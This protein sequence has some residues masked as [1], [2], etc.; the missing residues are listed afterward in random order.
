M[1]FA[2]QKMKKDLYNF[3]REYWRL[4]SEVEI[5][6]LLV[7]NQ[8]FKATTERIPEGIQRYYPRTKCGDNLALAWH[9]PGTG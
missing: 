2:K 5:L 7:G 3:L 9:Q 1:S 6:L 8:D 4:V